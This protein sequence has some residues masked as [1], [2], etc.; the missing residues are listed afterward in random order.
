MIAEDKVSAVWRIAKTKK[1]AV[2]KSNEEEED[3]D[4]KRTDAPTEGT[5]EY[6]EA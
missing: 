2:P 4:D 1:R 5:Y 3:E 6:S